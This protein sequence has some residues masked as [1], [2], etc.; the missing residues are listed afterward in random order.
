MGEELG[1]AVHAEMAIDGSDVLM[2]RRD[3]E[4]EASSDV[5]FGVALQ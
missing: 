1:A 5:F 2:R 4:G 3:A